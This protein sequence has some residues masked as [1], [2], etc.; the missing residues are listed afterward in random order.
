MRRGIVCRSSAGVGRIVGESVAGLVSPAARRAGGGEPY[1]SPFR[2][3]G[4]VG[5][6]DGEAGTP[7]N[8]AGGLSEASQQRYRLDEVLPAGAQDA[9]GQLELYARTV[10]QG[11]LHG[12]HESRR[13][14]VSTDFDHHKLYQPGDSLKHI[15][16]KAS[17]RHDR[18]F[19]KR[20]IEETALTVQMVVDRSGSMA[21]AGEES[22]KYLHA[23]RIAACLA[24]LI[25]SQ[26]DLVG[27][28]LTSR[29]DT[30]W[31][32]AG[33]TQR[34]L[35]QILNAL[36][37]REASDADGLRVCLQ[38]MVARGHRRGLVIAISDFMFDPEPV[39]AELARLAIQG[40]EILL[41]H[42]Q[43]VVEE[44]FP[45]NRWTHFT[46]LEN[47]R[48]LHRVDAVTLKRLY[49]EEYD[50]LCESWRQWARKWGAHR[51]ALP[52]DRSPETVLSEYVAA[53]NRSK[54]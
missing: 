46:D 30:E 41:V 50:R 34:H 33:S 42:V 1:E 16:W 36:A 21:Y 24:Y 25:S 10:V 17:A 44:E 31:I 51:V 8:G 9:L 35:A 32:P 22:S 18:Y 47:P 7:G 5:A 39:Q 14:G 48:V 15:D 40:H 23:A 45:F 2:T 28:G 20:Y 37:A 52:T 29:Q 54:A 12:A 43:D 3:A 6:T 4:K 53:R 13:L 26:N 19:V 38:T 27:L 49:R 11:W